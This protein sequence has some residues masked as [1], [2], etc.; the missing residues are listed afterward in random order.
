MV[1][2]ARM[3]RLFI[4]ALQVC[5]PARRQSF[6]LFFYHSISQPQP[7][8]TPSRHIPTSQEQYLRFTRQTRSRSLPQ[9]STNFQFCTIRR[10]LQIR[11]IIT[12]FCSFP[13][14]LRAN[15]DSFPRNGLLNTARMF[16]PATGYVV[17]DVVKETHACD[18]GDRN[19]DV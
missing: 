9:K 11:F 10:P 4:N 6:H 3:T 19:T 18:S 2:H 15:Y 17:I 8:S 16:L 14:G 13:P 7:T 12:S 1:F 5:R